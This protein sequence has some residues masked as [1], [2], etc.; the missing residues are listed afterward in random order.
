[1]KINELKAEM[2]GIEELARK[3]YDGY[4]KSVG[5][6]AFNGDPLLGSEEFFEDKSKTKQ[7]NGWRDASA[8]AFEYINKGKDL[9]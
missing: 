6:K 9:V 2:S 1:M 4:C 5:V 8:I 7:A 3:M